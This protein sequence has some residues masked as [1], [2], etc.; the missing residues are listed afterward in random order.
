M[1]ASLSGALVI[2]VFQRTVKPVGFTLKNAD[3]SA[4][5]LTGKRVFLTIWH[6]STGA[7]V[8]EYRSPDA[9]LAIT[10]P[11]T[12]GAFVFTPAD[13]AEL[14]IEARDYRYEVALD[15]GAGGGFEVVA[16]SAGQVFRVCQTR[17]PT[18]T[19]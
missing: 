9:Q 7:L 15:D 2:E 3:A 4:Y 16:Q 6:P 18:P 17:T 1:S 10:A 19:P 14:N 12:D 5:D 13:S 8:K 11:A